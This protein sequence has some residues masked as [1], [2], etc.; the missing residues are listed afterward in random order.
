MAKADTEVAIPRQMLQDVLAAHLTQAVFDS[1]EQRDELIRSL[2]RS[3][4]ASKE[5]DHD[6]FTYIEKFIRLGIAEQVKEIAGEWV[7]E[8]KDVIREQVDKALREGLVKNVVMDMAK[9]IG[10]R[11]TKGY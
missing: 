2:V 4:L 7:D 1:P 10:E 9:M 8:H 6:K 5:Y 11:L 3:V